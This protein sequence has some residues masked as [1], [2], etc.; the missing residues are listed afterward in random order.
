MRMWHRLSDRL[1]YWIV[2]RRL[3]VLTLVAL[4]IAG[5]AVLNGAAAAAGLT[6]RQAAAPLSGAFHLSI[7]GDVARPLAWRC[8]SI[9]I[10]AS[11]KVG[12]AG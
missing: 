12:G 4:M 11:P 8:R 9:S 2:H 5:R 7:G 10:N 3:V 1:A 6:G